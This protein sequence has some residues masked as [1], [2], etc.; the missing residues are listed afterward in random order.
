MWS[1]AADLP[2]VEVII[3]EHPTPGNPLGLKGAGEAG[4]TGAPAAVANAVVDA[5]ASG[6]DHV[7]RLPLSPEE[8]HGLLD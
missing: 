4:M 3:I 5:T 2:E 7:K 1:L 6:E 8:V